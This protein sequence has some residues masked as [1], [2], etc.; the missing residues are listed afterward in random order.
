MKKRNPTTATEVRNEVL[1]QLG[2]FR[3]RELDRNDLKAYAFGVNAAMRTASV[4]LK[5]AEING[6][7]I[8]LAFLK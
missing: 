1:A 8:N 2:E 5:Q 6:S 7:K 3:R 4:Q